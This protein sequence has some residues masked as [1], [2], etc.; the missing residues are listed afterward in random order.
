[1]RKDK[2]LFI[3]VSALLILAA[4]SVFLVLFDLMRVNI[5]MR[6]VNLSGINMEERAEIGKL[7][8]DP[9]ITPAAK[10]YQSFVRSDDPVRG[11]Q[12]ASLMIME[13]GDFECPYCVQLYPYLL[14]LLD[15][16]Q[17]QVKLVW[18]DFISPIHMEGKRA[19]VAARCAAEQGRFWEFH[20]YIFTNQ[21]KLGGDFYH[22]A[23]QELD[24]DMEKFNDCMNQ[25]VKMVELIGQGLVDGQRLGVDGTPYLF[26]GNQKVGQLISYEEFK[27]IVDNELKNSY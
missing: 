27:S 8:S 4:G 16:Y 26:I 3:A 9:L 13:F 18:K 21:S 15:E 14:R 24:L 19:A 25:P 6:Q 11:D 12:R 2:V 7:T 1:M 22:L 10:V 5:G 20:D 17:G 23:A